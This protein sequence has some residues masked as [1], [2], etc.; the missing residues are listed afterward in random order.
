[1]PI[2]SKCPNCKAESNVPDHLAGKRVKCPKC[3]ELMRVP[4]SEGEG[5]F[6]VVESDDPPERPSARRSRHR[7]DDEPDEPVRNKRR[8]IED[9]EDDEPVRKKRRPIED[10]EDDE[11]VRKKRHRY[12]DDDEKDDDRPRNRRSSKRSRS[13]SSGVSPI[14]YAIGGV[15]L[16]GLLIVVYLVYSAKFGAPND[17]DLNQKDPQ[18]QGGPRPGLPER[19]IGGRM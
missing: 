19:P 3:K 1:M 2:P 7:E 8:P 17:D 9:D 10:D 11:P 15:V 18:I 4:E 13:E 16:I 6:D 12:E 14:R 5:G